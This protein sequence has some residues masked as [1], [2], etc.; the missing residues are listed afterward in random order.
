MRSL[1]RLVLAHQDITGPLLEPLQFTYQANRSV[2]DVVN[3]GLHYIPQHLDS[4]RNVCK[5]PVRGLQLGAQHHH[6]RGLSHQTHP[7]HFDLP[8]IQE[9]AGEAGRNLIQ[10]WYPSGMYALPAAVLPLH[11]QL[12]LRRPVCSTAEICRRHNSHPPHQRQRWVC[13]WQEVKQLALLCSQNNL[14]LNMLKTVEMTVDFRRRPSS[15]PPSLTI[16]N[17]AVSAVDSFSF[18]GSTISQDL[19][20]ESCLRNSWSSFTLQS[21]S[22]F[23]AHPPNRAGK[24]Y[25]GQSAEIDYSFLL[26]ERN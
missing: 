12:H 13:I 6:P 10:H 25:N 3:M 5:D 24:D 20:W 15:L 7:A 14:E 4:P 22:L 11:Q 1:E 26:T 8:D 19:K 16:L 23:S 2:D 21:L 18:L 9:A 17:S